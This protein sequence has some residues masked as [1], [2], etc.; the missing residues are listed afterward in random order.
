M[1]LK[2]GLV[3]HYEVMRG[4]PSKLINATGLMQWRK[5][6]DESDVIEREIDL[7][8]IDW[9]NC[10][11]SQLPRAR[12]TAQLVYSGEITYLTELN[13]IE[14]APVIMWHMK[15]PLWL[16]LIVVRLAWYF[17]HSSQ[18]ETRR[19]VL[20]RINKVIDQALEQGEDTLIVGH[21][22][23]MLFMAK[24]LEKRGFK[25]PSLKRPKNATLYLYEKSI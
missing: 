17:N 10:Y 5:E 7:Q 14:I 9:Q 25:G 6:Y 12:K 1:I 4:Y 2:I 24:E 15:L 16:H 11:C 22:G 20:Q 8:N 19:E 23:I 13:E 3:R 18:P 21:G